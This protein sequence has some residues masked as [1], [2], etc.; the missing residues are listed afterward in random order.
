MVENIIKAMVN[1]DANI[2]GKYMKVAFLFPGQGSQSIGMGKEFYDSYD[3]AKE[4]FDTASSV[5]KVDMKD[6]LFNENEN[7]NKTQFT[8]PAILLVSYISYM[9][10]SKQSDITP[11]FA[12][13]H[14]L[15]EITA[16]V[17]SGSL[18][19]ENAIKLVYARGQLMQQACNNLDAGM[20][21]IIGLE[22]EIVEDFCKNKNDIWCA[23][24]N[25]SGQIV[26]AGS[27]SALNNIEED[28]KKLGAKR[29]VMLPMSIA[30]HCP[31]LDSIID[32]FREVL[33]SY[34][35]DCFKFEIISNATI[36]SYNTKNKA[37]DLLTMQLTKPVFYKQ[38][39]IKNENRID[40]FIEFGHGNVL[41]GLNKRLSS[42]P[43]YCISNN[44]S[45]ESTINE[46]NK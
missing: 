25:G 28:I 21:V 26:L 33:N 35:L 12:L 10:F 8:Q 37:L 11:E 41:K 43:T 14:S 17:I 34:L 18:S 2:K 6:L 32:E 30:S 16:N 13:G 27:K 29:F 19:F 44:A 39:I 38:S 46:I 23:N 1:V 9:L 3:V 45:L 4:L 20:A 15:G 31:L 40:C 22:D 5:L 7:I 24:Y 42:K 36:E